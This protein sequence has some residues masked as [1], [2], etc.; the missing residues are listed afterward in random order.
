[1]A[2]K[3]AKTVRE[4]NMEK[5]MGGCMA[6]FFNLFDRNHLH[7]RLPPA[8]NNSSSASLIT[9]ESPAL[10]K[11]SEKIKP[12]KQPGVPE[13][14]PVTPPPPA[15]LAA[16]P[17]NFTREAPRLS[18]DSRAITDAKSG[19]RPRQIRVSTAS[20]AADDEERRSPSV[21]ARL[22][23][24]GPLPSSTSLSGSLEHDEPEKK[25][26]L[27]RSTSESRSRHYCGFVD[28][29]SFL[30]PVG[31]NRVENAVERKLDHTVVVNG[32]R[33]TVINNTRKSDNNYNNTKVRNQN[34]S[35]NN[36][37]RLTVERRS[38]Y[39]T[40]DIFPPEVTVKQQQQS[41]TV[42]GEIERR[43]RVKGIDEPSKD[44]ETLKH[45]LE[46][47]QLK[48]L[49]H[50][51]STTTK[52]RKNV[53]LMKTTRSTSPI[54]TARGRRLGVASSEPLVS[55]RRERMA[56]SPGRGDNRS[57]SPVLRRKGGPLSVETQRRGNETPVQ[58]PR[59]TRPSDQ[60]VNRSPRIR[61]ST[62]QIHRGERVHC[63]GPT[64]A[65][66]EMST[67]S[68]SSLSTSS[69]TDIER[70]REEE[71]R[72]GRNLLKRCDKLLNSIAEITT[73]SSSNS[74]S[75]EL[76]PSP[77]S[78]LD[79]SFYKE[80]ESSP[81]PV[82]KR[83]IEFKDEAVIELEDES[84][85]PLSSSTRLLKLDNDIDTSNDSEFSYVSEVLRALH[86]FPEDNNLFDLIEKQSLIR[87]TRKPNSKASILQRK[88]IFD[89]ISEI[90][91]R[92]THLPP[93]KAVSIHGTRPM[94][95]QIWSEFQKIRDHSP[96]EDLF[97][98]ICG[99]LKK[100]LAGDSTT[101][102]VGFP[103]EMSEAVLDIERLIFKDL[104]GE[105][106]RDLAS[107]DGKNMRLQGLRRKLLF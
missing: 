98:I 100:D 45:I 1:M 71:H 97:E 9:S 18:L 95:D 36:C 13:K 70:W 60:T 3:T 49:L 89:T 93:W 10:S 47:L 48:G 90:L 42:Y 37:R 79:S 56:K 27:R 24:L 7:K 78:V 52:S 14:T 104:I 8:V 87:G 39:D 83:T 53:V 4:Q 6:G 46:A 44:L 32:R 26:Q 29:P 51:S 38:Y 67:V 94:S 17:L 81:S 107:I 58:S 50:S 35:N 106:I 20:N 12:E 54:A 34:Q 22:M 19:L 21:I 64:F 103:V 57:S 102:W 86:Y 105:I 99:V 15:A 68:G 61:K 30:P 85:S 73:S 65:E 101:G 28:T 11:D 59:M 62:V 43:L 80:D 69:H 76:Q 72:G 16:A 84:W 2:A 92:N 66:D 41:V 40:A 33:Q 63:G 82:K 55:P 77:V 75:T 88:L 74:N 5:Q 23:G 91:D 96:S 25:V 31:N